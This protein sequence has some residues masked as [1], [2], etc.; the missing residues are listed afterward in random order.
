MGF[1]EASQTVACLPS[2]YCHF[3]LQARLRLK[4]AR[5]V[6]VGCWLAGYSWK[7][8]YESIKKVGLSGSLGTQVSDHAAS[9]P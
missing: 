9:F 6:A 4:E 2:G 8:Y 3:D 5:L 1:M 7:L